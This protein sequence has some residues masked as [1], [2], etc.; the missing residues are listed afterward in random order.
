MPLIAAVS[1]TLGIEPRVLHMLN[2]CSTTE[3]HSQLNNDDIP[4]YYYTHCHKP[5]VPTTGE[6]E[7]G[8]SQVQGSSGLQT[9]FRNSLGN[10]RRPSLKITRAEDTVQGQSACL[11]GV[12]TGTSRLPGALGP[13]FCQMR[14]FMHAL[15]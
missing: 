15:N 3:I 6:A 12:C 8:S 9:E 5:T 4:N 11:A 7:A 10:L 2:T 14:D 1:V 13:S